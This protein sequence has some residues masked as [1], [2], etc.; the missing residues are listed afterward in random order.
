M[1]QQR[2]FRFSD[3]IQPSHD[4]PIRSVITA[5][6]ETLVVA[7]HVGPGQQIVPHVYPDGQDTWTILMGRGEYQID[8]DGETIAVMQGDIVVAHKGEVHGVYNDG[9]EPL[10]FISVVAPGNAAPEEL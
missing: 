10:V 2:Q 9:D 3:Y 8:A 5:S 6:D 7:W 4:E 1:S